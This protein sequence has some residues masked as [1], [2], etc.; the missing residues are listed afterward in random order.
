MQRT[1]IY[2]ERRRVLEHADLG[3]EVRHFATDVVE[4]YVRAATTEQHVED[5]DLDQLWAQ[6]RTVYPVG[7][8]ASDV[9][10]EHG[11]QLSTEVLLRE[12]TADV[13]LAYDAREEEM[14]PALMRQLERRVVLGVIDRKWREHLYEMDYLQ[15]GIGLR[16]MAQRN[17]L[18]E[19]QREGYDMFQAMTEGIKE[20]TVRLVFAAQ[21][22]SAAPSPPAGVEVVGGEDAATPVPV[23]PV[24]GGAPTDRGAAEPDAEPE[25]APADSRDRPAEP[26]VPASFSVPGLEQRVGALSY[27]APTLDG[28]EPSGGRQPRTRAGQPQGNRAQRRA[29]A[30][31]D[32]GRP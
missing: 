24:G 15:D 12:L 6:L 13:R 30:K 5:W 1:V 11:N 14:T 7:I 10:A 29:A 9:V 18:V 32:K 27:S 28:E 23:A 26:E 20:E 3:D 4:G 22:T 31:K 2:K 21:L 8:E 25:A 17:P 16:A 19:Y